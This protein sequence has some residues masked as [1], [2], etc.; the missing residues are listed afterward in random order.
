MEQLDS[1]IMENLFTITWGKVLFSENTVVPEISLAKIDP[2][3]PLD[4]VCLFGC[5]VTTGIGAVHNTA[6]GEGVVTAVF[7]L[8]KLI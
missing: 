3:A 4:K 8:G 1:L 5:G 2:E 6:K 7:G